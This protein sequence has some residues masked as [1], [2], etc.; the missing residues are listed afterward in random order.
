MKSEKKTDPSNAEKK[1]LKYILACAFLSHIYVLWGSFT[2]DDSIL[3]LD[4]KTY[5]CGSDFS[6]IFTKPF[7]FNINYFRPTVSVL[8][9]LESCIYGTVPFFYKLLNLILFTAASGLVYLFFCR[10]QEPSQKKGH[11]IPLG[12]SALWILHPIQSEL[13]SQATNRF[14]L[15]LIISALTVLMNSSKYSKTHYITSFILSFISILI[16]ETAVIFPFLILCFSFYRQNSINLSKSVLLHPIFSFAGIIGALALRPLL[17]GYLWKSGG[18]PI[19]TGD[20]FSHILLVSRTA[21][22]VLRILFLLKTSSPIHYSELPVSLNSVSIAELLFFFAGAAFS[23][24]LIFRRIDLGGLIACFWIS[25]LP[26]LQ[27]FPI[28]LSGNSITAERYLALPFLFL[29]GAGTKWAAFNENKLNNFLFKTAFTFFLSAATLTGL[30]MHKVWNSSESLW[31]HAL[32][33]APYSRIPYLSLALIYAAEN[34]HT[35][36]VET[37]DRAVSL[38][39]PSSRRDSWDTSILYFNQAN[40]LMR[41]KRFQAAEVSYWKSIE[42]SENL[43]M[44]NSKALINLSICLLVLGRRQDAHSILSR[45]SSEN[46]ENREIQ[47]AVRFLYDN[48][49]QAVG[50]FVN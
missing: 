47:K 45:L 39:R 38:Y 40:S 25:L 23:I 32:W 42:L 24:F 29:L 8:Y 3:F 9:Y 4:T 7:Y 6:K 34:Q 14:D 17:L 35:K 44:Q 41:L 43:R 18:M 27:I 31:N 37:A 30:Y 11:L 5:A 26:V 33:T 46:P 49:T 19:E 36:A 50:E 28:E 15:L 20:P 13:I 2:W 22:T 21:V 16:K 12:A 48:E 10:L 1:Y